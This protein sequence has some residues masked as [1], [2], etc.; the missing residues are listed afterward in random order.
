MLASKSTAARERNVLAG[1]LHIFIGKSLDGENV[2]CGRCDDDIN[3]RGI[4]LKFVEHIICELSGEF[5]RAIA[6]PVGADKKFASVLHENNFKF[7]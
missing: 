1:D 5:H 3:F 2:E 7:I 4:K 6:F